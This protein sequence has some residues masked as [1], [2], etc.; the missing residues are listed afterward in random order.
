MVGTPEYMAP[1][2]VVLRERSGGY[3]KPVD[4]WAMG[5]VLYILL[6]GIHPFQMEDEEQMLGNIQ[7]GRWRWLG[8]NWTKVS[9]AAKDLITHMMDPNPATRFTI[10]Q[11]LG[12]QWLKGDQQSDADLGGV[13]SEL[14]RFQAKKK[15]RAAIRAIIARNKMKAILGK[16]KS[17][18]GASSSSAQGSGGAKAK[19]TK[20]KGVQVSIVEGSELA[21]KD[22]NGKSDPYVKVK[23]NGIVRLKT[24]K[25]TKT[26]NPKWDPKKES[27]TIPFSSGLRAIDVECWDWDA[28]GSHDFMGEFT[29]DLSEFEIGQEVEKSFKLHP[30]EVRSK[31]KKTDNVSGSLK[32][33]LLKVPE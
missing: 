13:A 18:S 20:W 14:R 25:K 15:M 23:A 33:K 22:S 7:N 11:C 16:V 17:S 28:V 31:K 9:E 12:H 8:S 2:I 29:I 3:S 32:V 26:L 27:V 21:A 5:V 1:E 6:S 24:D 10:D 19:P 4:I 30:A